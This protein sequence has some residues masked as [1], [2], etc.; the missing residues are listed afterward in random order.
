MGKVLEMILG[1]LAHKPS[2]ANLAGSIDH[3]RLTIVGVFPIYQ[4]IHSA[5]FHCQLHHLAETDIG[6]S[7]I[8]AETDVGI[9]HFMAE[10]EVGFR[11]SRQFILK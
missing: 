6:I 5:T 10:A 1:K 3:K 7:H 4:M 11:Q 9:N 8:M 2:F